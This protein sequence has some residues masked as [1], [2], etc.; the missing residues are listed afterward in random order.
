MAAI[1][2][3]AWK[4]PS[5]ISMKAANAD[6]PMAA[7]LTSLLLMCHSLLSGAGTVV[8]ALVDQD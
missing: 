1:P 2:A 8:L 3:R 6:Q 4:I 7:P 5:I